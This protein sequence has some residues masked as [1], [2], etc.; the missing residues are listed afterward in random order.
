M[1]RMGEKIVERNGGLCL[2][3]GD[4]VGQVASQTLR[5]I[6]AVES[7][8][9]LPVLRPLAG[10]DKQEIIDISQKIGT[11]DISIRPYEDCC[12]IFVA[13]HPETKPKRSIIESIEAKILPALEPMMER[14]LADTEIYEF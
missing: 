12:T 11:F 8:V 4:S 7:A 2:V 14:A 3:T 10:F 9:S 1:L 6:H 5:G 13:K